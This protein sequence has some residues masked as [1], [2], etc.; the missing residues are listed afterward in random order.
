MKLRYTEHLIYLVSLS[1]L[2]IFFYLS[3]NQIK[4]P[5]EIINFMD[6]KIHEDFEI[7]IANNLDDI[8]NF[9]KEYVFIE[10]HILKRKNNEINI[11][12]NL[13]KSFAINNTTK[14]VIFFDNSK[15]SLNY[16]KLKY[17]NT[18]DLIDISQ[19]SIYINNYLNDYYS[20]L[21]SLFDIDQIEYIDD[22]RYNLVLSN[23]RTVCF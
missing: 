18:I 19:N 7:E 12:L 6:S 3:I 23:G 4:K 13:K 21:S 2:I 17:L 20:A 10:S 15:A 5:L 11:Q 9:L 1:L 16:F 8:N 22:R 14:E